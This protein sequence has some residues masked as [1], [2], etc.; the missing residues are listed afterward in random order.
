MS[1]IIGLYVTKSNCFQY[2][3]KSVT[4]LYWGS[5]EEII[6][7]EFRIS[8]KTPSKTKICSIDRKNHMRTISI[9]IENSFHK[10]IRFYDLVSNQQ[11]RNET[12]LY[13]C[14]IIV[15]LKISSR[16]YPKR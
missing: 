2:S 6:M 12:L 5:P 15:I 16:P 10:G 9:M 14:K 1:K 7:L 4:A 11:H 13:R 8:S 3:I